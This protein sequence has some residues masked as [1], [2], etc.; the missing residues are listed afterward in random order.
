MP[1]LS[2]LLLLLSLITVNIFADSDINDDTICDASSSLEIMRKDKLISIEN[3]IKANKEMSGSESITICALLNNGKSENII[4]AEI[5]HILEKNKID[6]KYFEDRGYANVQ[7]FGNNFLVQAMYKD[8]ISFN[9][10]LKYGLNLNRPLKYD[11][12]V[13]TPLDFAFYE[14]NKLKN[15][16][17]SPGKWHAQISRLKQKGAK[18]CKELGL[19]CSIDY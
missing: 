1:K 4:N 6:R 8:E 17:K 18:T 11:K 5:N 9:I 16:G 10:F 14:Y 13:G 15:A 12:K 19:K 2:K 3:F 7:C